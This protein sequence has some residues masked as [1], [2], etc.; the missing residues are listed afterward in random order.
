MGD[1]PRL[2]NTVVKVG[3]DFWDGEAITAGTK[4]WSTQ[5]E[6]GIVFGAD[7]TEGVW[8]MVITEDEEGLFELKTLDSFD[9]RVRS[10]FD[11]TVGVYT[12]VVGDPET[13]T[14]I[15]F[16]TPLRVPLSQPLFDSWLK[17]PEAQSIIRC[18]VGRTICD[19]GVTRYSHLQPGYRL[20]AGTTYFQTE[21]RS[22]S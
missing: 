16:P 8:P 2:T 18:S 17:L 14:A 7:G 3:I 19:M 13:A 9:V 6:Q 21:R 22:T 5:V 12:C 15:Y 4:A 20:Y 1:E 11:F 10:P